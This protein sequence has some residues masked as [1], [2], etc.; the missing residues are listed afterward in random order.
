[1]SEQKIWVEK[2][3]ESCIKCEWCTLNHK[4]NYGRPFCLMAR[5]P[6]Y[7]GDRVNEERG[8]HKD[9]LSDFDCPLHSIKDHDRELVEKVIKEVEENFT[10][11]LPLKNRTGAW[12]YGRLS[13]ILKKYQKEFEK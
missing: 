11:Y 7:N 13:E 2:M 5:M 9:S 12:F 3:P 1:M 6:L 10:K 8:Q 4:E